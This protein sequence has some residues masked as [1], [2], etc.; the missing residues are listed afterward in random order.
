MFVE[1]GFRIRFGNGEV[2]DFYADSTA[3]KEAWM[4]VLGE[5]VGKGAATGSGPIKPWTELVLKRERSIKSKKDAAGPRANPPPVPAKSEARPPFHNATNSGA[6]RAQSPRPRHK[7]A[8]SQPEIRSAD[9][10][11]QKTRSMIF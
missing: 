5:T 1:E 2:I 7:H 8:F 3:D 10:R 6:P 9:V 4:K 11:G